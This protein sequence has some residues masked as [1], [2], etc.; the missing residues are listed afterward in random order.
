MAVESWADAAGRAREAEECSN[1]A[2]AA[3]ASRRARSLKVWDDGR[4]GTACSEGLEISRACDEALVRYW[5]KADIGD[6]LLGR[7]R[8]P[9]Y[10]VS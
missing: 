7:K 8:D 10:N 6:V 2:R 9:R 4:F 1:W 3:R 5:H